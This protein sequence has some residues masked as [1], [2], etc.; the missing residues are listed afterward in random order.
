MGAVI[1]GSGFAGGKLLGE[2]ALQRMRNAWRAYR[3]ELSER[4]SIPTACTTQPNSSVHAGKPVETTSLKVQMQ[5]A[6]RERNA[7]SRKGDPKTT[8]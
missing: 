1:L 7:T 3:L 2:A 5:A 8:N 6:L 4:T